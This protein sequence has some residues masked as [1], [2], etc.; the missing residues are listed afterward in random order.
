[1]SP[2]N[3]IITGISRSG[4]SY[5]CNLLHRFSNCVIIN[6]P[7]E[8]FQPLMQEA[9]PWSIARIYE[10]FRSD[11][12]NGRPIQNKL[13]ATDLVEDTMVLNQRS[14]YTPQ[15]LHLDFV[16]GTKHTQPYLTRL[17]ALRRVL[18]EA[19]IVVCIRDPFDTIASW[20]TS[21]PHLREAK[22]ERMRVGNLNDPTL[23]GR[24]VAALRLIVNTKELAQRRAMWW[25]YMAESI[26]EQGRTIILVRYSALIANP[27]RVLNRILEGLPAGSLVEPIPA[28]I[29]RS[30]RS[31]LDAGDEQAIRAICS[32]TA[33]ELGLAEP[34]RS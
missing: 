32:Q 11:I 13:R 24:Q 8:V 4:T 27:E 25:N 22:A 20:K 23:T 12:W 26:L 17:T 18:P 10:Q 29:V 9:V 16:F 31:E 3:L 19:R 7:A 2:A 5:L 14:V 1:M 34:E 6:E 15:V 21:F 30:K 28:S 33:A